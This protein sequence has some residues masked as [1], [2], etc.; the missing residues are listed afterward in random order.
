MVKKHLSLVGLLTVP[1]DIYANSGLKL[2]PA[3]IQRDN[4]S[5]K[6]RKVPRKERPV[7]N[8][9]LHNPVQPKQTWP[10][11]LTNPAY[12]YMELDFEKM[13]SGSSNKGCCRIL[14]VFA[15]RGKYGGGE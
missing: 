3:G 1:G 10:T 7:D 9:S 12:L 13:L 15:I 4:S 2:N 8:K 14:S 11:P 5:K 6:A